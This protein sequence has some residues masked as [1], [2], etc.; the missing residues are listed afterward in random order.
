MAKIPIKDV[1]A[2]ELDHPQIEEMP[3]SYLGM[4]QIGHE[5]DRYLQFY[6]RWAGTIKIPRQIR[7]LFDFG[8]IAEKQITAELERVK[9]EIYDQQKEFIGFAGHWKGHIDGKIRYVPGRE[10][11]QYLLEFKTHNQKFFTKLKKEGVQ[12]GFPKHYDQAQRYLAEEP[13]L[14]GIMYVGYNKNDS[15]YHIEFLERDESRI[16]ELKLRESHVMFAETLLPRIGTGQISWH[17]CRFCDFKQQCFDRKPIMET[18][19]SCKNV[20]V[21]EGGVFYCNWWDRPL[22]LDWQKDGCDDYEFDNEFFD[23]AKTV[24]D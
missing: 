6:F 9:C 12:K 23:R 3:R 4:S 7:R 13:D 21:R 2:Y 11:F 17:E 5:C 18:C 10:D 16:K 1:L 19:R 22:E 8:H 15:D 14:D 20:E 24:S